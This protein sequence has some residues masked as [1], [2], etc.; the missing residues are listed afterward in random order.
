VNPDTDQGFSVNLDLE[1]FQ[2]FVNKM[3]N[4][5]VSVVYPDSSNQDPDSAF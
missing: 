3:D 1:Q 4:L 5:S 2:V